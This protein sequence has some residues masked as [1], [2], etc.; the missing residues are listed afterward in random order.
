MAVH[1][2]ISGKDL[3]DLA[4]PTFCPRCFW[5]KRKAPEGLPFQIFPG[6]FSSIDSYTKKVVHH[7]IDKHGR[8]PPSLAELGPVVSYKDPPG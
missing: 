5:V 7:L 8:L 1:H 2:Q 3:G 6:I 4:K